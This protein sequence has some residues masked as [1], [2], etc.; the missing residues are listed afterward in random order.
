M[1][2][3]KQFVGGVAIAGFLAIFALLG[4]TSTISAFVNTASAGYGG[5]TEKVAIC[6][7]GKTLTVAS[8]AVSAHLNHGDTIGACAI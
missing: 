8:P 7:K 2:K 4:S 6:H 3:N 1:Y 5:G